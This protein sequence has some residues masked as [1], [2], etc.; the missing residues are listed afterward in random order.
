MR[1]DELWN[2]THKK[3]LVDNATDEKAKQ[4]SS[5]YLPMLLQLRKVYVKTDQEKLKQVDEASDKVSVQC[6]KYEQVQKLKN[7]Y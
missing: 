3:H 1:N 2:T 7:S 5:N 4:L 6:K